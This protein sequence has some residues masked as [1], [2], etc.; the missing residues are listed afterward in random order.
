MTPELLLLGVAPAGGA[1]AVLTE[2]LSR[3]KDLLPLVTHPARP[4]AE[5]G[6]GFVHAKGRLEAAHGWGRDG[7]H[8]TSPRRCLAWRLR[9][10]ARA[11]LGG[12]STELWS[13]SWRQDDLVLRDAGG[14]AALAEAVSLDFGWHECVFEVFRGADGDL[15]ATPEMLPAG[16]RLRS[17]TRAPG[18]RRG[19]QRVAP[20]GAEAGFAETLV[21]EVLQGTPAQALPPMATRHV[22]V[23]WTD[24]DPDEEVR[25]YG[26]GRLVVEPDGDRGG[27]Y[28]DAPRRLRVESA[29]A[30]RAGAEPVAFAEAALRLLRWQ[31][32]GGLGMLAF[33]LAWA[34]GFFL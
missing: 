14:T 6:D 9:V 13:A 7:A 2:A 19:V 30:A 23:L 17:M 27:G 3:K 5:Q 16:E 8:G 31:V 15:R 20:E 11:N 10:E 4:L 1:V 18:A 24:V 28:R 34:L 29:G 32:H 22:V 21:R 26:A 25:V 12:L 33:G